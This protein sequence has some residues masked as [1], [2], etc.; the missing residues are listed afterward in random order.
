MRRRMATAPTAPHVRGVNFHT[1]DLLRRVTGLAA[2]RG[3]SRSALVRGLI[4]RELREAAPR[5]DEGPAAAA[6]TGVARRGIGA[7]VVADVGMGEV[8]RVDSTS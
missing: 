5:A 6:A 4:E 8:R 7:A 3:V 2:V 1:A